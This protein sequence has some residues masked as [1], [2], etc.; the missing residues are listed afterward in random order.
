MESLPHS[1]PEKAQGFIFNTR[2]APLND[3]R[4][5]EALNLAFDFDWMNISLFHGKAKQITSTFPNSALAA[6][7]Q[8][9]NADKRAR[10]KQADTLLNDA[11]WSVK[12][13]KR[14]ELT[15]LLNN[16][17]E[18]K[19]ALGYAR[20]LK[21]LGVNLKI[22]TLDTAQFFG[23]LNDYDYDMVSWRWVNSLSPG[24][25][26]AIYWGCD[27]ANTL[28]SRNYAGI[29]T[30]EIDAAIADL[31]TVKTYEELSAQTQKLDALIMA[32]VAFVPL[33]YTGVDTVAR[34]PSVNHPE[35]QS[36]YGIGFETW[37]RTNENHR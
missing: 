16:P 36:L 35:K 37:W 27:A 7:H 28:G 23:A 3:L 4:V 12:N 25:E 11:G 24:T 15:L 6:P 20:D 30:P 31:T 29:C 19:I 26:Q 10:L 5:R 9:Q 22:R 32:Q 8:K 13:G 14:F 34:F 33:Y 18:E 17:A 21:R 2:R 1:R